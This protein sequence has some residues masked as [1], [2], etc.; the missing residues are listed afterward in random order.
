VVYVLYLH[1]DTF[2]TL[3]KLARERWVPVAHTD[4]VTGR[5]EWAPDWA[6]R[7]QGWQPLNEFL[8]ERWD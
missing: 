2:Y 6:T 4:P 7:A 5:L 3:G 8:C 1:R